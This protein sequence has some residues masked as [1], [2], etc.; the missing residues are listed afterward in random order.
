MYIA[1]PSWRKLDEQAVRSVAGNPN[2]R[3]PLNLP[4][5]HEIE[6]IADPKDRL[7]EVLNLAADCSGRR[8]DIFKRRF[9]EH[10]RLL[11]ERLDP[12]GPVSGLEAWRAVV[13]EVEQAA[14]LLG[15]VALD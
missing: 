5:R 13:A 12:G 11:L 10:R 2:G 9:A 4:K 6:R 15:S 1:C 7:R 14:A 3:R 8:L